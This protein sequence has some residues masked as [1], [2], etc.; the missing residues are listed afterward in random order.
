M[1]TIFNAG[2]NSS[3]TLNGQNLRQRVGHTE[4]KNFCLIQIPLT[5]NLE[6]FEHG[7][8]T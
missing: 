4:I 8:K 2:I 1:I 6:E 7:K 5:W 3:P